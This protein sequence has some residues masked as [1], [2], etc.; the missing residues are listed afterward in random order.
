[1]RTVLLL[2]HVTMAL[3]LTP[4]CRDGGRLRSDLRFKYSY[5]DTI[6]DQSLDIDFSQRSG[7]SIRCNAAGT[8]VLAD[9]VTLSVPCESVTRAEGPDMDIFGWAKQLVVGK[10]GSVKVFSG[11]LNASPI[12]FTSGDE[13]GSKV[14][15]SLGG[16]YL[17]AVCKNAIRVYRFDSTWSDHEEI[18]FPNALDHEL[19]VDLNHEDYMIVSEPS[20]NKVSIYRLG[21]YID[22]VKSLNGNGEVATAVNCRGSVFAYAS[23]GS[24]KLTQLSQKDGLWTNLAAISVNPVKLSMSS[25]VLAIA[26]ADKTSI[27]MFSNSGTSY[28]EYKTY[29]D[30]AT[31]VRVEHDDFAIV[32]DALYI[33]N[34]GPSTK[35]RALQ[36]L[37]DGVCVDCGPG[38]TNAHD[39]TETTCNPIQC[40]SSQYAFD[41]ACLACP[42]G[43]SGV[44][45]PATVDSVCTCQ[46]GKSFNS[47]ACNAILCGENFRVSGNECVPCDVGE[48]NTAGDDASGA[49]TGCFPFFCNPDEF[50]LEHV[51]T[52]CPDGGRRA[53]TDNRSGNDTTCEPITTCAADEYYDSSCQSCYVGTAS[54]VIDDSIQKLGNASCVAV[55]CAENERVSSN[56]CVACPAGAFSVG[57]DDATGADTQCTCSPNYEGDG[58]SCSACGTNE[59]SVDGAPCSCGANSESDGSGCVVCPAD[60]GALPGPITAKCIK[61]EGATWHD[62][63]SVA[64]AGACTASLDCTTKASTTSGCIQPYE[65]GLQTSSPCCALHEPSKCGCNDN[66]RV[67]NNVCTACPTGE[68][69]PAG[70]DPDNGNTY[71]NTEGITLAFGNNG[72]TD[73]VYDGQND[74]DINLKVGQLY[75]FMRDSGGHPLRILSESDVASLVSSGLD[76]ITWSS[77]TTTN[78]PSGR[79]WQRS[80]VRG[81]DFIVYGGYNTNAAFV[82]DT[83]TL[84]WS[85]LGTDPGTRREHVM[86]THGTDV[87]VHGGYGSDYLS[88]VWKLDSSNAWSSVTTTGTAPARM[89]HTAV[90]HGGAMYVFGGSTTGGS[91][92]TSVHKLDLTTYEWSSVTTTGSAASGRYEHSAVVYGDDMIVYGGSY[93]KN[94]VKKLNLLTYEWS[95]VTTT[96]TM[97]SRASHQAG[98]IGDFM[99]VFGGNKEASNTVVDE[100]WTLNLLTNEWAQHTEANAPS[101]RQRFTMG[102]HNN[103]LLIYGTGA[104]NSVDFHKLSVTMGVG[105][106]QSLPTSSLSNVDAVQGSANIVHTFTTAGTYYYVCTAHLGMFG[107]LVVSWE[108]CTIDTYGSITLSSSCQIQSTVSLTGATTIHAGLR[109]TG[110]KLILGMADISPAINAGAYALTINGFEISG[111]ESNNAL[112]ESTT[113]TITLNSVDIKGNTRNTGAMFKTTDGHIV[114]QSMVIENSGD[115]FEAA[116][117]D[118][119]LADTVVSTSKTVIKQVGGAVLVRDVNITGGTLADLTDATS[120]FEAV[121]TDGGDGIKAVRS[122]VQVERSQ[123]KGHSAAPIQFDSSA[124]TKCDRELVIESSTFEDSVAIDATTDANKPVVKVIETSFKSSGSLVSDNGVELYVI[125]EVDGEEMTTSETKTETCLP[126]QCSHK[127]LATSCKVVSGKGTQCICDVGVATYN[128]ENNELDKKTTVEEMLAL[129]FA[130]ADT[131]DRVVKLVDRNSRYIPTQPTATAAKSNILLLKPTNSDGEFQSEKTILLKPDSGTLCATFQTWL[132]AELTAC[133]YANG[134]ITADCDGNKILTGAFNATRRFRSILKAVHPEDP[135]CNGAISNLKQQCSNNGEFYTR[136]V[137][138]AHFH[139]DQCVCMDGM[140]PNSGGD[141]CLLEQNLCDVNQRV[142]RGRCVACE[143]ALTNKA[144]DDLTGSDTVCDDVI[145]KEKFFSNGNGKCTICPAGSFNLEGDIAYD[146][147]TSSNGPATSCC[148]SGQYEFDVDLTVGTRTCKACDDATDSLRN[149]FGANGAGLHCCR[150]SR[151]DAAD[152]LKCG[153]ILDYYKKVCQ[154]LEANAATCKSY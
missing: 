49:D 77:P 9:G 94:D 23:G 25:D 95:S 113:G 91:N 68:V 138:N 63:G 52:P 31:V 147:D 7:E 12:E 96:G 66:F 58:T 24:T 60:S 120:V 40:T 26:L 76:A 65:D 93:N 85:T 59:V 134:T 87:Y 48:A 149:R 21:I 29:P 74:P 142:L 116:G 99:F 28:A 15:M 82:L 54:E 117:G 124:C 57:G 17:A 128:I 19:H 115:M 80:T 118:I 61:N 133:H 136:C 78:L 107:K 37:E 14:R 109:S 11:D 90:V 108:A 104:S 84:D 131:A 103:D 114:G 5:E 34:D 146:A 69:R 8:A 152:S 106:L 51:C 46:A 33:F 6:A 89:G 123:F 98:V 30:V 122:A 45:G 132:C 130:T 20:T 125:D 145:C 72:D 16:H 81:D 102:V 151:L 111:V 13:C 88:D 39:N 18:S 43:A 140:L 38:H 56:A 1:M 154:P 97:T 4:A 71:C 92:P 62:E 53:E 144:G 83:T 141:A 3:A 42:A 135:N 64:E 148:P 10:R 112:V 153:R 2:I 22:K 36:K 143:G 86:V 55:V 79:T 27:Y 105:G 32:S 137:K 67:V 44:A 75:T 70:D 126:Y 35:C 129:L 127:P 150:G 110:Q 73:F 119:S 50:V 101:A 121:F 47:G 41:S 100:L 139:H